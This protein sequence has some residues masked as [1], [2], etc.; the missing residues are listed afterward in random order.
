MAIEEMIDTPNDPFNG[1]CIGWYPPTM[2][3]FA[4]EIFTTE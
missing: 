4:E 1:K 3:R 2:H